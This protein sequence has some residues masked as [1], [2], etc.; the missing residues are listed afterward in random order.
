MDVALLNLDSSS[1]ALTFIDAPDGPPARQTVTTTT[2]L[3]SRLQ[4]AMVWTTTQTV[5]VTVTDANDDPVFSSGSTAS[6]LRKARRYTA[7]ATMP[8]A[9]RWPWPVGQDRCCSTSTGSWWP[10]A[11]DAPDFETHWQTVTTTTRLRSRREDGNGGTTQTVTVTVTD[12]NDDPVFSSE[13]GQFR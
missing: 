4:T 6:S 13:D 5:T 9:I 1:G 7:A 12:A 10:T 2:R 8:T 3:R 11:I